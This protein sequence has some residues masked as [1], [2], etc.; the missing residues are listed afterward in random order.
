MEDLCLIFDDV[1]GEGASRFPLMSRRAGTE[2]RQLDPGTPLSGK[3]LKIIGQSSGFCPRLR[4]FVCHPSY[5]EFDEEDLLEF[6]ASRR[7]PR[8]SALGLTA[9]QKVEVKFLFEKTLDLRLR[10]EEAAV[11]TNGL[12]LEISYIPEPPPAGEDSLFSYSMT[13]D[14]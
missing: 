6:I 14:P 10:M 1:Q 11:D 4:S 5:S 8:A 13:A 9:L 2:D 12:V 3:L 7:E